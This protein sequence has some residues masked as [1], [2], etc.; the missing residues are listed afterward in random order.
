MTEPEILRCAQ[1]DIP[2]VFNQ[3]SYYAVRPSQTAASVPTVEPAPSTPPATISDSPSAAPTIGTGARAY[4]VNQTADGFVSVRDQ[5][6]TQGREVRRLTAGTVIACEGLVTGER[7][8]GVD[9]WVNCPSMG[10]Y[11]FEELL[12]PTVEVPP[13]PTPARS[14]SSTYR[15]KATADGFVVVR[16]EPT[17][18]SREVTRLHADDLVECESIVSGEV[19]AG[20]TEWAACQSAGGYILRSLLAAK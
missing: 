15:V 4:R 19:I 1:D 10:G 11:I 8:D 17:R 20:S 13:P 3:I 14:T 2:E 5:P 18:S 7:L 16:A 6:S 12:T 9:Q